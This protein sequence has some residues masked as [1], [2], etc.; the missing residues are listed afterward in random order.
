MSNRVANFVQVLR[1]SLM[2]LRQRPYRQRLGIHR[3]GDL[4][5]VAGD[6]RVSGQVVNELC[7]RN[8]EKPFTDRAKSCFRRRSGLFHAF[9]ARQQSFE[10]CALEFP[11]VIDDEYLRQPG[12]AANA[13]PQRHHAGTIAWRIE[14]QVKR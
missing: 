2:Q 14:C 10:V 6:L 8:S 5:D 1:Q 3:L 12:E 11:T 13:L 9:I 7:V 4:A